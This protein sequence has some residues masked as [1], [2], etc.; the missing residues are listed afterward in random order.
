MFLQRILTALIRSLKDRDG[1]PLA[2]EENLFGNSRV[3][4]K[5]FQALDFFAKDSHGAHEEPYGWGWAAFSSRKEFILEFE[6]RN[7]KF[8]DPRFFG[9][10]IPL[11]PSKEPKVSQWTRSMIDAHRTRRTSR[12]F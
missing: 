12:S 4:I 2:S 5:N 3:A 11:R 8:S 7:Q 6:N 9:N 10:R 1:R